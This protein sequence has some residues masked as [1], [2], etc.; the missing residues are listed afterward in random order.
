MFSL[1]VTI[2]SIALV[3]ALAVAA[4]FYGGNAWSSGNAKAKAAQLSSEAD[5]LVAAINMFRLENKRLPVGLNELTQDGKY[6]SG[7]PQG[8]WIGSRTFFQAARD[9]LEKNTCL[10]FN[11]KRGIPFVPM[12]SDE[13]YRSVVVCCEAPPPQ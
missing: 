11:E 13:V 4:M 9:D 7:E 6:L 8:G 5:Q 1:I 2:I 12:C 10:A 3:S